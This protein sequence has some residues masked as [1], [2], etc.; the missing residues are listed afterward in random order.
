MHEPGRALVPLV[1]VEV[2]LVLLEALLLGEREPEADWV[3]AAA[4]AR[5]IVVRGNFAAHSSQTFSN[6]P[7]RS[8]CS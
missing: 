3:V 1:E 7:K 6:V 8:S 4:P 5:G 2:R